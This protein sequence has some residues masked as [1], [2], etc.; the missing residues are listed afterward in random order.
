MPPVITMPVLEL[1]SNLELL[2][3]ITTSLCLYYSQFYYYVS[4]STAFIE[5][6]WSY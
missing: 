1:A 6:N 5:I 4:D 3:Q 2:R